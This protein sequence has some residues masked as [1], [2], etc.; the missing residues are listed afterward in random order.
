MKTGADTNFILND[1]ALLAWCRGTHYLWQYLLG[2][3]KFDTGFN[4]YARFAQL[5]RDRG[6]DISMLNLINW[7]T[8]DEIRGWLTS[9]VNWSRNYIFKFKNNV[10]FL[11]FLSDINSDEC[12]YTYHSKRRIGIHRFSDSYFDIYFGN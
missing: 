11:N 10:C 2:V 1:T 12:M 3:V 8:H 6:R 7:V 9:C 5:A 4:Y